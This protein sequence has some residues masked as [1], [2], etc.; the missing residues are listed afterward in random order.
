M[1][2]LDEDSRVCSGLVT[3]RRSGGEVDTE[4]MIET[5]HQNLNAEQCVEDDV[6]R[7]VGV[8]LDVY[9]VSHE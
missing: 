2:A 9:C 4:K 6:H 1:P 7:D 8:C 3:I 5:H